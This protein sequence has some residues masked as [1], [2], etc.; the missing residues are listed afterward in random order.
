MTKQPALVGI[1]PRK[2]L[3]PKIQKERWYHIPVESAPLNVSFIEYLAFYFPKAFGEEHRYKVAYY[4]PVL[5]VETKKRIELFPKESGHERANKDYFQF[6]LGQI[7][8][9]PK[10]IPCKKWRR[11]IHIPTSLEKLLTAKEINDLW[12][13]SPLEE[14]MYLELKRREIETERQFYV[15]VDG[16]IYCLDF[17][18]FCKKGNIDLEC[19]GEKY[20]TL[21][22]AL[23][24]DR[25][26]NNQLASFGWSVLRFSGKEIR[27]AIGDCFKIIEKTIGN[28]GGLTK[29][30][31]LVR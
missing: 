7:K 31:E 18:I 28:L 27:Q 26:R 15:K 6:H 8:E 20:H 29:T 30:M 21:P 17:G 22:E 19:D 3:W 14:K 2:G 4:A 23:A 12:D 9:L 11:I 5:G 16:R 13:T 25:K 10:P 1:V 24:R